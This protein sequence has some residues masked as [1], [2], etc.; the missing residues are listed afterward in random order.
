MARAPA[1]D[2][3]HLVLQL[4]IGVSPIMG[5]ARLCVVPDAPIDPLENEAA[6]ARSDQ[7]DTGEQVP[8]C[9]DG[10]AKVGR[11]VQ[12]W[13]PTRRRLLSF[14]LP[15]TASAIDE[16]NRSARSLARNASAAM[17]RLM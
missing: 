12:E 11:A 9:L 6:R 2:R 10:D 14:R 3:N 1:G 5:F 7:H 15:G 17:T 16:R 4:R 13:T 8:D